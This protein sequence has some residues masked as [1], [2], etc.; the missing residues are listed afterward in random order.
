MAIAGLNVMEM[1]R[2]Q[3]KLKQLEID[4]LLEITKA[5]NSNKS[6]SA[7]F[8]LFHRTLK[9]QIGVENILL[10]SNNGDD[11]EPVI[12]NKFI[13]ELNPGLINSLLKYNKLTDLS[14]L[15]G[16]LPEYLKQYDI[17]IPVFHKEKPLAY[18]LMSN[19][20]VESYEP[21]E[22]KVKFAQTVTNIISVAIENK[23]LFKK[24]VEQQ[25]FQRELELAAQVQSM[26]IPDTLPNDD[27]IQMAAIYLPHKNIGG[28]YYDFIK[29]S[30]DEMF[31]CIAD[32]SGK[33]IAAAILM[34]NFQAQIRELTK[35]NPVTIEE[36][37]QELNKGVLMSTKGEKFITLF[38]GK[39]NRKT[40]LL[41]YVNSGH[42][43]PILVNTNGAKFLDKGTT[44]LG[45]FNELPSVKMGQ[46]P[47][48]EDTAI[49]C[50]TDGL[51]DVVN[52][53]NQVFP[54]DE[55]IDLVKANYKGNIE[56]LNK[57][58]INEIM[59]FK[60]EDG[61]VSDDLTVLSVKILK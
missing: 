11:W 7:L 15:N 56:T 50:F 47:I 25:S 5:I 39:Y 13:S 21:L 59:R 40:R 46:V 20:R 8:E 6:A 49:I 53:D 9:D 30:E 52:E 57:K 54:L 28:D 31:F 43:P 35:R 2:D 45:M 29:L 33:G 34:A 37:M 44:I 26:L 4:S 41:K 61:A 42:N 1:L 48:I 16:E 19:P 60:D 32:I 38:L 14:A 17:L 10:Y 3:L 23:R 22:D 18:L 55:L 12:G 27:K 51:T 36:Y 24:E 58:I